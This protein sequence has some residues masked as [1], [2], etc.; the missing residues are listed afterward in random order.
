MVT[1]KKAAAPAKPVAKKK[2]P[3]RKTAPRQ[4]A[5]KAVGR[6]AAPPAAKAPA[7]RRKSKSPAS[8]LAVALDAQTRTKQRVDAVMALGWGV[9]ADKATFRAVL[10][11]VKDP[12]TPGELRHAA[13][14]TLQAAT[15]SAKAFAPYRAEYL[16]AMRAL[17]TD[18]DA[19]MRQRS[20]GILAREHD[21]DTQ[22]MLIE[23]LQDHEKAMLPPEKALQL[24]S[25]DVHAGAYDMARHIAQSPPNEH[26]RVEALRVLAADG[27]SAGMFEEILRDKGET[28]KIRQL[29]ATALNQL[30][31]QRLQLCARDL[32]LDEAE[33]DAMRSMGLTALAHFGN[34]QALAQDE[35]VKAVVSRVQQQASAATTTAEGAAADPGQESL[36]RA[37]EQYSNRY[38]SA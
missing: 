30:A 7:P 12:A 22:A 6:K 35:E 20:F 25:Y 19:E 1:R 23:G 11:L 36:Q 2:T 5:A 28:T 34:A 33:S 27:E 14:S 32:T 16:A 4:A 26:A 13:L 31:P 29:A 15:F 9:C 24:L 38:G 10:D 37:A 18:E 3:A 21:A 17:R 8:P